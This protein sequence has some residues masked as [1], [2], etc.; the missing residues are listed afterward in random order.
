MTPPA[1]TPVITGLGIISCLGCDLESVA[2]AL[3]EGQCGIQVDPE[4]KRLGFRSALT[5]VL[6][7]WKP[8]AFGLG[9]RGSKTMGEP[10]LYAYAATANALQLAGLDAAQLERM[11]AGIVFGNDSTVAAGV[12]AWETLRAEGQTRALGSGAIFK[13]M[14]STVS[15]NLAT[16][17]RLKG[18][19]WTL[20]AACASGAHAVGQAAM[21]IRLGL[22]DV[23]ICGGAQEIN[24]QCMAS[25]DAIQAFSLRESDPGAASRP[26][27]QDRDGLVPSGGAAA[28]VLESAAHAAQ[29]GAQSWGEVLGYGFSSDGRHLSQP[30]SEGAQAAMAMALASA[31]L[32]PAE[33]EYVNAHATSTPVGDAAE[34][35]AIRAVLPHRPWVSS[36]KGHTGHEC[37]MAGASEAVYCCL[38][39]AH[40][41]IA[42]NLN[43]QQ[44]D[45][46]TADLH[47]VT[48]TLEQKPGMVLSNS[49]GFGG[50]NACLV[51]GFKNSRW[52]QHKYIFS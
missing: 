41:F 22:Q 29:R 15:M 43:Y 35:R 42:P 34:A 10:A 19:N 51:L 8:E 16:A 39:A 20:S 33:V 49:F 38:M 6:R 13:A 30:C 1:R 47:I 18:A 36:T 48:Q 21:L 26:F 7:G 23:V 25:F 3:A 11:R 50:T 40:G 46:D 44:G 32:A 45:K 4:R 9:K 31:G 17:F 52:L 5:G 27:D 2:Q 37:W 12:A 24:P 28:L 14:N